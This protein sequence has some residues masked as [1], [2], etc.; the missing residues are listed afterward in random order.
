MKRRNS[1]SSDPLEPFEQALKARV[2]SRS[3]LL[4]EAKALTAR[5]R[6]GKQVLVGG[7][8]VLALSLGL[9]AADPAWHS[10]AL[11]TAVGQRDTVRLADGTRVMLN[12]A[13]TLRVETRLR[14]R[15]VELVQG[16]ASFTVVH[17][18]KPF[19]VRSQGVAVRDIG[20]VF[21]VRSDARGVQVTVLEGAVAVSSST[22]AEQYLEAGQ[23]ISATGSSR[24]AVH[25]VAADRAIAWQ[26]GK[27]SFDGT[28]LQD[29]LVDL[30]RYRAA[31]VRLGDPRLAGLRVSGEFDSAAVESLIDMLPS[32]L[33][34]QLSRQPDGGVVVNAR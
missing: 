16:E 32:I 12:S 6:K 2:P 8:S 17:G 18:P 30:Q 3:E 33:P 10:E 1:Q 7:L 23:Q 24:G 13:T 27:L 26:H 20:T 31:P 11:H 14:S 29:V 15:Q 5:Q 4:A 34:V 28:P 22:S 25:T 9:W 21:N 19:T